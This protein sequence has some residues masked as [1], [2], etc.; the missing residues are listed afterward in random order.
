MPQASDMLLKNPAGNEGRAGNEIL[1]L[2]QRLPYPPNKGDRIRTFHIID[3]LVGQGWRIHLATLLDKP[4]EAVHVDALRPY[5]ASLYAV[6]L[7]RWRR[8]PFLWRGVLGSSLSVEYFRS[9]RLQKHVDTL[10]ATRTIAATLAISAPMA[11]YLRR[12]PGPLPRR[13]V[14]DLVDVDSEKWRAYAAK[15]RFPLGCVHALES[16]LLARYEEKA[17]THFGSVILVSDPEAALLRPRAVGRF[18]VEGVPNG[19]DADYF[20]PALHESEPARN[21]M[22]FC[23]A[24]DYPPNIDAVEWFAREVLPRIR[25]RL[26]D[27]RFCIAGSNPAARVRALDALPGVQVTG[28]VPDIRPLVQAATVS[29]A[30]MR[31]ARGVQN[32]VLEAMAM[33]KAV[34][35]TPQALEGLDVVPGEAAAMAPDEP[36][37]FAQAALG[38]LLDGERRRAMGRRARALVVERHAW[39]ACLKPLERLLA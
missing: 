2:C 19:V 23:G 37:A 1:I 5:C 8:L 16:R 33:G 21:T 24:M 7:P 25:Q 4:E 39:D 17:G 6:H 32:K 28:T 20:A 22:I 38:L 12:T 26:P 14:L 11:E 31:L 3:H 34:L 30:P 27:V 29:V 18:S 10:L 15:G 36:Q 13:M 35:A 9:R